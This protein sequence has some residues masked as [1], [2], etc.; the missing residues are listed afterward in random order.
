M[1]PEAPPTFFLRINVRRQLVDA[2]LGRNARGSRP[3]DGIA[4]IRLENAFFRPDENL[5]LDSASG[6]QL[7]FPDEQTL[8][9]VTPAAAREE[10]HGEVV[11]LFGAVD[12]L[13]SNVRIELKAA[14]VA[15]V[16][17]LSHSPFLGELLLA[18]SEGG[19]GTRLPPS[20]ASCPFALN[21]PLRACAPATVTP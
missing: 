1:R 4:S 10:V 5:A 18:W 16:G 9:I 12:V 19:E 14:S 13:I 3:C 11:A 2:A 15:L 7:L 8:R 20:T 21:V 6:V 17:E